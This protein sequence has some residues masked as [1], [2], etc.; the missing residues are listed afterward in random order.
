[1]E[2]HIQC[3]SIFFPSLFL[4]LAAFATQQWPRQCLHSA[5]RNDR[6][7]KAY[8]ANNQG[9]KITETEYA[10]ED[11]AICVAKENTELLAEINQA[12]ADLTADG[13]IAAIIEKYIPSEGT[14]E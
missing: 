9:L 3:I 12:L 13:T 11:Y 4:I 5:I 7:S 6:S 2:N 10:N 14:A 8:V 1:M